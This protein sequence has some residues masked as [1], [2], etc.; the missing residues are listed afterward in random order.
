MLTR[1]SPVHMTHRSKCVSRRARGG[2]NGGPL[3]GLEA[4]EVSARS[5]DLS[6]VLRH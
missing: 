2:R 4:V 6:T 1:R 3:T 5:C